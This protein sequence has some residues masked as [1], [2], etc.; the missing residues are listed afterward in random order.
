MEEN[1]CGLRHPQKFI[2]HTNLLSTKI[3]M[4]LKQNGHS[5][6]S[7]CGSTSVHHKTREYVYSWSIYRGSGKEQDIGRPFAKKGFT[8]CTL[9][10][11]KG[12]G[13]HCKV[14]GR[15]RYSVDLHHGNVRVEL[16]YSGITFH[17]SNF[18]GALIFVTER[19]HESF[20]VYGIH[21]TSL[22]VCLNSSPLWAMGD[23][24][25]TQS[26]NSL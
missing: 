23:C 22:F 6:G 11:K 3:L 7:V 21:F 5:R 24:W 1:F 12:G 17:G 2:T 14:T 20:C 8:C 15:Q 25:W 18:R 9:F 4:P 10:L 26:R 16:Q 19:N 13:I